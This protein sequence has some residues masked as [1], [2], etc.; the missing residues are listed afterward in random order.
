[1]KKFILRNTIFKSW[2][3]SELLRNPYQIYFDFG[4]FN[5]RIKLSPLKLRCSLNLRNDC[6]TVPRS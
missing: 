4:S 2:S 6:E 1:M 5:L 3:E